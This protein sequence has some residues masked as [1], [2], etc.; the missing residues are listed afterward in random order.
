MPK[1]LLYD[2]IEENMKGFKRTEN[3]QL[4]KE[5]EKTSKLSD[6][7]TED[8]QLSKFIEIARWAYGQLVA[9]NITAGVMKGL[10][11]DEIPPTPPTATA[12]AQEKERRKV[13]RLPFKVSRI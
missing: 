10:L 12:A 4:I 13:E 5:A 2:Y 9:Y 1:G 8:P 3:N 6:L 7:T 11:L